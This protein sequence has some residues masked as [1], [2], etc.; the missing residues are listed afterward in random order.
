V[1]RIEEEKCDSN[2]ACFDLGPSFSFLAGTP[3]PRGDHLGN[4]GLCSR[5]AE[6]ER[7]EAMD[8]TGPDSI[9][10]DGPVR[11]SLWHNRDFVLLWSGQAVSTLGAQISSIAYVLLAL[12][13]TGSAAKAGL[14]AALASVASLA[15][16]LPAGVL[17]DT[18]SRLAILVYADIG[19]AAVLITVPVAGLTGKLSF[20]HIVIVAVADA[21]LGAFFEPAEA[22]ALRHIVA[23][24]QLQE[25][26]ARN[27]SR[28]Y[29]AT[30]LGPTIGGVLFGVGRTLPFLVDAVSYLLSALSFSLIRQPLNPP[31][32]RPERPGRPGQFR[33]SLAGGLAWVWHQRFVRSSVLW[34]AGVM[35]VF[36]SIGLVSVV[37]AKKHGAGPT[38][39]GALFSITSAGGLAGALAAPRL[40]ARFAP[41]TLIVAF[42]WLTALVTPLMCVAQSA[43]LIGAIGAAAF[44]LGPAASAAILGHVL[45]HGPEEIQGR[46]NAAI[47]LITKAGLPIGPLCAG[48]MLQWLGPITTVVVYS[49][50]LMLLAV[51]STRSRGIRS[52]SAS[53]PMKV[54]IGCGRRGACRGRLS[55]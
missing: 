33:R 13:M 51:G 39:L 17:A 34:L 42:G 50:L 47:S 15:M 40:T 8:G 14:L 24:E 18:R 19:R 49:S 29:I 5:Q 38:E 4:S 6:H 12:A 52:A 22:A 41:R 11:G 55:A 26:V 43:Y 10:Q 46:A 2:H 1:E 45:I 21:A 3:Q 36:Q 28:A 35:F 9:D 44:F 31:T 32:V 23:V 7:L 30:L 16:R 20:G 48:L 37:L 27:Q 53:V 54:K 25:A